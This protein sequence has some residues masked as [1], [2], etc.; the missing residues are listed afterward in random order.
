MGNWR[1]LSGKSFVGPAMNRKWEC[2]TI[3]FAP[4]RA[5]NLQFDCRVSE[6]RAGRQAYSIRRNPLV[7]AMEVKRT[8]YQESAHEWRL[9]P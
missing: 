7:M 6:V 1:T 2:S 5:D 4:Q 8:I 9:Q 3:V